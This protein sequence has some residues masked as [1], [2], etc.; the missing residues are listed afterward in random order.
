MTPILVFAIMAML[1]AATLYTVAVFGERGARELKP[2]HLALFWFGL[3][4]DTTGTT[5]M[6]QIAGGWK[7]DVHG[8]TGAIAVAL[9]LTHSAWA[10]LALVLKK[11]RVL[12]SFHKFSIHVWALWMAAFLSGIVLVALKLA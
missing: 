7:W 10:T 2:W 8:V 4:F 9:M 6:A 3:V 1:L 12:H 5:L 11:E